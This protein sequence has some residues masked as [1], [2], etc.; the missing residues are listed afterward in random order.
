MVGA[1][2]LIGFAQIPS[3]YKVRNSNEEKTKHTMNYLGKV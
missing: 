2:D 3:R 1:G